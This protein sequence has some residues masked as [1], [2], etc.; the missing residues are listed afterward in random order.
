MIRA[1]SVAWWSSTGVSNTR[2]TGFAWQVPPNT[3]Q[4]PMPSHCEPAAVFR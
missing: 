2:N 4:L 3:I 1:A